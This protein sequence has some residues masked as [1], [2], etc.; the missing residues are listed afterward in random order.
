MHSHTEIA[1][2]GKGSQRR[3]G[4]PWLFSPLPHEGIL[5]EIIAWAVLV[6][7]A[8]IWRFSDSRMLHY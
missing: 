6:W 5:Q 4:P 1:N 2:L 3:E 8:V 7:Q